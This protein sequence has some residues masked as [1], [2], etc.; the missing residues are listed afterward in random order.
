MHGKCMSVPL[1]LRKKPA[2]KKALN[3]AENFHGGL[4]EANNNFRGSCLGLF[5]QNIHWVAT[6][7]GRMACQNRAAT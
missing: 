3:L 1:A 4:I 6:R 7:R 2:L 5:C